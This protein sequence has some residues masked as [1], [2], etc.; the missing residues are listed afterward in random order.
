MTKA[1]ILQ[2]RLLHYR[3]RLFELLRERCAQLGVDLH[4]VHG[5]PTE[6][7][8]RKKDTGQLAWADVVRNRSVSI[9]GKDLVWQPFPARHRDAAL[10]VTMQE[11]R[12]LSNYPLLFG[13][14]GNDMRLAYWGH[15][16]NFQ[17]SRPNGVR[18]RWKRSLVGRVDWWFAYTETTRSILLAD[19]YPDE[20]I[21]V[22]DNAI[23]NVEF[24]QELA[25][26]SPEE[27]ASLRRDLG[28]D[29]G[30]AHIGL[31]CGSLY[32][33]KRLD[34]MI[35]AADLIHG[36]LPGF[37]L[38]IIGDGPSADIIRAAAP[39][40]PWLRW[41][42]ALTGHD[43]AKWFSIADLVI[44]PGAVGLHI[45]DAFCSGAPMVTA[46]DSKHGPELAYLENGVNGLIVDGDARAYANAVTSL[47]S[48]GARLAA[49][50][51][52]ALADAHRYSLANM[53]EHF[54]S[55]I[56]RCVSLPRK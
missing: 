44:N 51:R 45:L 35:A 11:N 38:V 12:L 16:R 37:R 30:D 21:T 47:L 52:R 4:V 27:K 25:A 2:Y 31:F 3:V 10:V 33:D 22:L 39:A 5:Q 28:A 46:R 53:V 19:G 6:R 50:E 34:Y 55:G 32:A 26:V 40:R 18:E 42:G 41:L 8:A 9:G 20:R 54:A 14:R 23:D 15:G 7:E 43:K 24:E 1:V 29:A 17:S 13:P 36:S 48:D 49:L 56:E